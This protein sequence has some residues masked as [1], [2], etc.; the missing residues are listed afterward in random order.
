MRHTG[1]RLGR[2]EWD[3]GRG[4]ADGRLGWAEA[5]LLAAV[6]RVER[7]LQQE[8]EHVQR[9]YAAEAPSDR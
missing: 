4:L 6:A 9:A 2:R 1:L 8:V 5:C 3:L 7:R